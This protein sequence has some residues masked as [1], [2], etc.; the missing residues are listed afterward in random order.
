MIAL[1]HACYSFLPS[2]K[3]TVNSFKYY[4][5]IKPTGFFDPL[6][7]STPKK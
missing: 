2:Q 1:N 5:D 3:P 7:L 6:K 4:G